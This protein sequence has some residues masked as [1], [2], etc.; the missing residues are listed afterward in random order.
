MPARHVF[1]FKWIY[2]CLPW[3]VE[4]EDKR[5][6]QVVNTLLNVA[7]SNG[8]KIKS[9][10]FSTLKSNTLVEEIAE[11]K[12]LMIVEGGP[13]GTPWLDDNY[14]AQLKASQGIF[15]AMKKR[16]RR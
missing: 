15:E 12:K 3:G 7:R 1:N 11:I 8:A 14:E 13:K 6:A 9:P 10:D 2:S 4:V 16:I 5:H